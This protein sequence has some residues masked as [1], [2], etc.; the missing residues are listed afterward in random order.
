MV[1]CVVTETKSICSACNAK[2]KG[3]RA[4]KKKNDI[5]LLTATRAVWGSQS[6][7]HGQ[8]CLP[9]NHTRIVTNFLAQLWWLPPGLERS[10]CPLSI[11]I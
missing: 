2:S 8:N 7:G 6:G 11:T 10:S 9:E 1:G 3:G 5:T 4:K